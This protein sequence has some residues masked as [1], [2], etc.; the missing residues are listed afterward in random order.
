M[1]PR[2]D[3]RVDLARLPRHIGI[4]MDGNGRW[5]KKRFLPRIAGHREG[6]KAVD[7]VVAHARRMGVKA[8]TLYSFSLE[9]WSRPREE[10]DA[11]MGILAEYLER[12][13]RRML[14]EGIRF[15]AIGH[16]EDLP[17]FAQK[18]VA[19]AMRDTAAQQGMVLTLAL[20]Y[21]S[22]REIADAARALAREAAAGKL[23]PEDIEEADLARHLYTAALPELD[24]LIR[25]SGELRLSNYLLWQAA[26]AELYFTDLFWPDFGERELEAAVLDFQ[27]RVRKFGLT[28]E[29]VAGRKG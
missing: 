12:E 26:Y 18:M 10:V 15:N 7:R 4:I 5:A 28:E 9:N 24:L 25:T 19:D 23:D 16:L 6:V 27:S 21:G 20:S 17:P 14:R 8:L 29:Q 2:I 13:L 1:E 22:R 11:L 3:P